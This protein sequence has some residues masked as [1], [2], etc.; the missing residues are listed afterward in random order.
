MLSNVVSRKGSGLRQTSARTSVAVKSVSG[1]RTAVAEPVAAPVASE[2]VFAYTKNMPG[3]TAPFEGVFDPAGFL[4][5]ASVK[6]VRRW[7]ESEI[8]HGR[9]AM[10]AALGFIVG[11]QLQDFPLF[12]NWD[13]RVSGP[14][15]Y[16]FQQIG[17]GFWEPLLIAIGV[18]ESYR[19]L[20]KDD[21]EPGDLGFD[22]LGLKPTD[23]EEL[24]V[25]QTKELNNGRLAM[26][27]IAAFV[28]QE[29]VEQTEIF[30]HLALR[31]EKE[32]ILELDDIERDLGLPVTPLPDNLKNL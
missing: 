7:R 6:D 15:I 19:I 8:T 26:I 30:E 23:P 11:E 21:Y 28:A 14:A 13:G 16:H 32:A 25:M 22:P 27:A 4:A 20:N 1:R 5:T 2:D 12:F 29:L 31:F 18:A 10:L 24:K 17:Q 3:V 9:V